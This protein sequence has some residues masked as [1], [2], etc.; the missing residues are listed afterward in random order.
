MVQQGSMIVNGRHVSASLHKTLKCLFSWLTSSAEC[1]SWL[2]KPALRADAKLE[3]RAIEAGVG[4]ATAAAA[5]K[6]AGRVAPA[7]P[8]PWVPIGDRGGSWNT[9]TP[10]VHRPPAVAE[11]G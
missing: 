11:L 5:A 2:L 7:T 6:L 9:E 3:V 8:G 4:P 1:S 10:E